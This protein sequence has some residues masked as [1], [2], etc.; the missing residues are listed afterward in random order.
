MDKMNFLRFLIIYCD[1]MSG[2]FDNWVYLK[3]IE[4][5][6]AYSKWQA[7]WPEF[8]CALFYLFNIILQIIEKLIMMIKESYKETSLEL[9][10]ELG[11]IG[12]TD[13]KFKK[14]CFVK[15]LK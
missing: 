15:I 5:I 12:G 11:S 1:V 8:L 9:T 3:R 7:I 14:E 13:Y 6:K 10:P 2:F 4:V